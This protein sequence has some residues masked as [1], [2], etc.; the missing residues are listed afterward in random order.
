[1]SPAC[2]CMSR[3]PNA[4][5]PGRAL[6]AVAA[7]G[8]T[9]TRG[10]VSWFVASLTHLELYTVRGSRALP[11]Q[12]G[13]AARGSASRFADRAPARAMGMRNGRLT[14]SSFRSSTL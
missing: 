12:S 2:M 11:C 14:L 5:P 3:W 10:P 8:A 4:K 9:Q 6:A 13:L 1:M 7:C